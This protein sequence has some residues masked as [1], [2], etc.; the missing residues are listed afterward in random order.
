M[1][2]LRQSL[3]CLLVL[4]ALCPRM[5]TAEDASPLG[6]SYVRTPDL[7]LIYFDE[8]APL[9]PH[10]VSTFSNSHAWQRR[11]FGWQPSGPVGMLLQ[12]FSDYGNGSATPVPRN[13]MFVDVGPPSMA[14][15]TNPAAERMFSVMN[16]E[17]VHMAMG[18][19]A[20][21]ED[22]FWRGLFRGKVSPQAQNPES[23]LYYYLTVPRFGVPRWYLEGSAV[24]ME[25]WMGGGMGRAQG[26]YDEMVFRAKVRD[27]AAFYDPLG[28]ASKATLVDFQSGANA[29]LY[30]TRFITYLAVTHS[31]EKVLR[32][33]RRDEDSLR[34]YAD[35]F[36]KVFERP[37]EQAWQE[38]IAFER[39]FQQ[40]NLAQV[41]QHPI[42]PQQ[43]LSRT[44]MGSISRTYFDAASGILYGAFRMPGVVE[45]VGALNTRDGSHRNLVDIKDAMHYRV[46]SFAFDPASG[47]AFYTNNNQSERDLMALDIKTG[48]ARTLLA[49]ARIGDFA[50][51]PRD[52]S[53]IGVRHHDG[54]ATLV[55]VA[56]PYDEW[57]VVREL[58]Y[59]VVPSDLDIS[60]D[61][62]LLS[63]SVSERGSEQFV[64]VWELD[65]LLA[66]QFKP[67]SEFR[68]GQSVPEGFVFSRDGRHLYGSSYYTGVSNIFRYEVATGEIKAVSNAEI[69]F[70][71]P[72]ELP[73][74]RMLVLAYTGEGFVPTTIDPK[75]LTDL[76][77]ISFLGTEVT[78]RHPVVT[79]WQV[80]GAST[81]DPEKLITE[82]G[83]Y[84][85]LRQMG[86]V[87]AY[88]VLQGYKNTA[89][90][91][92]RAN[93]EDPIRFAQISVTAAWT[94]DQP[95]DQP[96]DQQAHI[97]AR[98]K[99]LGWRAG[100]AWNKSDF[101]DLFGPTKRSRK[102]YAL[103]LGRDR[104]LI[105]DDPRK[106][107]LSM[108]LS[109]YGKIDTLPGAQNVASA[110]TRLT[111]AEAKLHYTHLRR[112]LGAVDDEKGITGTAAL[113]L[114]RDGD[115]PSALLRGD[116]D[117][118]VALPL[119]HSSLWSRTAA[120]TAGGQ[121]DDP[122]A[123]FYFG[124]FGNNLVDNGNVKR[125]REF[126]AMPGFALDDIAGR[127]FVKQ[128]VEWTLPPAVFESIGTPGF[129]LS[130]ARPALFASALWADPGGEASARKVAS[131]G[132]QIDFRLSTLH[133]YEMMLSVGYARGFERSRAAR[134][135]WMVSLK[136]L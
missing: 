55:R 26:G 3:A 111:T 97:D 60:A 66:G 81:L 114:N 57:K 77:A 68:F 7:T 112:S 9:V 134:D 83:A 104:I 40:R 14:F 123:S 49:G 109:H 73:D 91:G 46:A 11:I 19:K 129:H 135:E 107:T 39:E 70:F 108:D 17:L 10:V 5:A 131:L 28:L 54:L 2:A 35:Q 50:F 27:N 118:G 48:E 86:L 58:P 124:G 75:P 113:T 69:G 37:L 82:R 63:A 4:L 76:S 132:T 89:G 1:T 34:H 15:E 121:R 22:R 67:L 36:K 96:G 43:D 56:H 74:D 29:Y 80:P 24:F 53:L 78:K 102:G 45:H 12:D 116:F 42:T 38:W 120:G 93:F 6:L 100:L 136:I 71:R 64:R 115:R 110:A 32:W 94:P 101:Y 61:G 65:Q 33:L 31:P 25:T 18:D 20:S 52:R 95:G 30:G 133:W 62:K 130:W 23:L 98:A 125:Y 117:V 85:P 119:A 99:Y 59:G 90:I 122:V 105:Y 13:T 51:N 87:N 128:M 16:H 127:H 8:L 84:A 47:T 21:A 126:G 79:T 72:T 92:L 41:R 88:P 106:L 44:A 103:S